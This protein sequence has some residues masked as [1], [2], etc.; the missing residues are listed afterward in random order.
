MGNN[1][2]KI[3]Y[4]ALSVV[5]NTRTHNED[6]LF[7]DGNTRPF[8]DEETFSQFGEILS[9]DN[10]MLAVFDGIGGEEKGE[11]ASSIAS[12]ATQGVDFSGDNVGEKIL[13]FTRSIN[14][15]VRQYAVDNDIESMGTT[16]AG[17]V[18]S[19]LGIHI[20]NVGD[21]KVFRLHNGKI[22]QLSVDHVLPKELAFNNV[23][24]QYIGM[25]EEKTPL[26][27]AISFQEYIP[28]DRY[29]ICSDGLTE[30]LN[31]DQVGALCHVAETVSDA[32]DILVSQALCA[33]GNDNITVIV[34]ELENS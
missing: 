16:F 9:T 34:C 6:N 23:I 26:E 10:K 5:G 17:V 33:G 30:K 27:P 3:K 12:N 25:K 18:F 11:V 14:Q 15:R 32:T 24:T 19:D 4:H 22:H 29:I 1:H 2:Y 21:S 7:C 20:G 13:D 28:G 8:E 31:V